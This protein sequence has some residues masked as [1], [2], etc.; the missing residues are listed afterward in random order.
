M[1]LI[2]LS[3]VRHFSVDLS[4]VLPLPESSFVECA[5]ARLSVLAVVINSKVGRG[6]YGS[7]F[8]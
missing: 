4:V 1:N 7:L 3:Y 6:L 8:R 5:S 2:Q